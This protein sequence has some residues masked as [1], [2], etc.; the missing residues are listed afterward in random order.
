[1]SRVTYLLLGSVLAGTFC[2]GCAV[3]QHEQCNDDRVHVQN[4]WYDYY[5]NKAWPMPFR[6]QDTSAVLS[7]FEVQRNNGW[8]L[9]NTLGGSMFDPGSCALNDSGRAH[10]KWIVKRSPMDRRVVFVLEGKNAEETAKRI[11]STQIA[12]SQILPTGELPAIYLTDQDAPGS[13]GAYQ[14]AVSRAI[15]NSAPAPRLPA[16]TSAQTNS[17]GSGQSSP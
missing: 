6:A 15:I 12:I 5:R 9:N 13:S 8:K 11:E 4:F 14:T 2:S 7:Y 17:S 3:T 16:N 1:M 10:V